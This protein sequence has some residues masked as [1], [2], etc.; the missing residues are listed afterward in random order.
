M[1]LHILAKLVGEEIRIDQQVTDKLTD[2]I[3]HVFDHRK[4]KKV[5]VGSLL[6]RN[7]AADL[8]RNASD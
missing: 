8:I 4:D 6:D 2:F 3:E 5:T 1:F 7:A